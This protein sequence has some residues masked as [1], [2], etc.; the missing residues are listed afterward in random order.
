MLFHCVWGLGWEGL[1]KSCSNL[2]ESSSFM[3]LAFALNGPKPTTLSWDCQT[4]PWINVPFS[5]VFSLSLHCSWVLSGVSH[6]GVI[7]EQVF[8]ESQGEASRLLLT[9]M[10]SHMSSHSLGHR[11][12]GKFGF[13]EA[14][15]Q[16][17]VQGNEIR[18]FFL[19]GR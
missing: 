5:C 14:I 2:L 4:E 13:K 18:L 11:Q 3:C 7:L 12:Y 9:K 16:V 19:R 6:K 15:W 8:Q 10:K 1:K 17:W